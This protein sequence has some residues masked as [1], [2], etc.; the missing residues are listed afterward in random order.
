MVK[1]DIVPDYVIHPAKPITVVTAPQLLPEHL[2]N[3][4]KI[5]MVNINVG[6]LD[7]DAFLLNTPR[8]LQPKERRLWSAAP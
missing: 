5:E 4:H 7:R 6:D 8:H 2:S 1:I 3:S